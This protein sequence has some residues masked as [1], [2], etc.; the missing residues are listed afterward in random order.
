MD[1]K[2]KTKIKEVL[3]KHNFSTMY[4]FEFMDSLN[5]EFNKLDEDMIDNRVWKSN[6]E[7]IDGGDNF[8]DYCKEFFEMLDEEEYYDN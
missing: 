8:A 2:T 1:I 6:V 7:D 5:K 3:A 4:D